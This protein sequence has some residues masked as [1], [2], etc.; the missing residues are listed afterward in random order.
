VLQREIER[1]NDFTK[2]FTE[3]GQGTPDMI[4][5]LINYK[6]ISESIENSLAK[7][8]KSISTFT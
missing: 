6:K 5:Y 3:L 8:I 4:G 7:P 1:I 2:Y